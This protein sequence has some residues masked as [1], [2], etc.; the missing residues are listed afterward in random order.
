[1]LR[2]IFLLLQLGPILRYV[3]SLIYGIKF[4]RSKPNSRERRKYYEYMVYEDTDASMLRLF[5]CFMEAAPQLILQLYILLPRYPLEPSSYGLVLT[6]LAAVATSLISLSWSLVSYQRSLRM[7]LRD[8]LNM[9][10]QVIH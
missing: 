6:Q 10:W 5:E 1:M 4:L 9:S 3:D 2:F 7:S 8:K